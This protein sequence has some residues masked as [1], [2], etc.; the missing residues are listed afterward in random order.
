VEIFGRG[1]TNFSAS[2]KIWFDGLDVQQTPARVTATTHTTTTGIDTDRWLFRRIILRVASR[3]EAGSHAEAEQITAQ[4]TKGRV[5]R[6]FDATGIARAE[7]F[8]QVLRAQYAKL[9]LEGT[10]AI[11]DIR[12]STTPDMLQIEVRGRSDSEPRL[13]DVPVAL[14]DHPDIELEIHTAMI[15]KA[16]LHPEIRSALETALQSLIDPPVSTVTPVSLQKV[17]A[18]EGGPRF[19][20]SDGGSD[21]LQISWDAKN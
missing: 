12:C 9:P 16:M 11:S 18:A 2:K 7:T 21:W 13:V 8:S 4:R 1:E 14:A 5:A 6:E 19:H 10:F 20:W 15:R 17:R 3:R